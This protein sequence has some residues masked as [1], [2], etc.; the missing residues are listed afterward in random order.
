MQNLLSMLIG[1]LDDIQI[2]VLSLISQASSKSYFL[3]YNIEL[4]AGRM[5]DNN[6][7]G[8]D[9]FNISFL[10]R[11]WRILRGLEMVFYDFNKANSPHN[12]AS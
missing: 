12:L 10:K 7:L 2:H 5:D 6:I 3:L 8:L 4:V 11:F 9:G 1:S